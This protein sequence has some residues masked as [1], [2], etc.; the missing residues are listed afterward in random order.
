[1][2]AVESRLEAN[3]ETNSA[4]FRDADTWLRTQADR[5]ITR[6]LWTGGAWGALHAALLNVTAAAARPPPP[7][8]T[9]ATAAFFTSFDVHAKLSFPGCRGCD[10]GS[11]AEALDADP[12]ANPWASLLLNSTFGTPADAVPESF[13]VDDAW[14]TIMTKALASASARVTTTETAAVSAQVGDDGSGLMRVGCCCWWWWTV[15]RCAL[16]AQRVCA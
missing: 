6:R 4:A 14:V 5:P 2:A 7:P 1:M 16:C 12:V 13:M 10:F 3:A 9:A 15:A 11:L 8:P